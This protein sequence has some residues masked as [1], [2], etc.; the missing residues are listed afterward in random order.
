MM[1]PRKAQEA[2]RKFRI[3]LRLYFALAATVT[4]CF[5]CLISCALVIL[6]VKLFYHEPLTSAA[7]ILLCLLVC[8]LSMLLGGIMMFFGSIHLTKPLEIVSAAVQKVAKG[9]FT[10]KIPRDAAKRGKYLYTNELDELS[11]NVNKMVTELN[12]MDYMRKDFMSNV[13]HEVKTPVAAITGFT[14]ILLEDNLEDED[15]KEYLRVVNQESRR[16]SILCENMLRMSRLDNQQIVVRKDE[17][18]IDEQIRKCIIMLSEKWS[19]HNIEYDLQLSPAVIE[20]DADLLMQVWT[21]LID[22]AIKY[23]PQ[24][25]TIRIVETFR[26]KEL[27]VSIQDKGIGISNEKLPKIFDKFYQ[28]EESHKKQ[29]NGL[30]LSIVKRILEILN[31]N[32]TYDSEENAGTTVTV[33]IPSNP[34]ASGNT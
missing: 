24:T 26:K 10:V 20:S 19:G 13:S 14:E 27:I 17:F 34:D 29:G 15:R 32:I 2:Q 23:S 31:G 9:D 6:G 1:K 11:E 22:N 30:G 7:V 18:R 16:L 5:A 4:L 3:T 8:A 25:G 33:R 28:C 21:N 12:G